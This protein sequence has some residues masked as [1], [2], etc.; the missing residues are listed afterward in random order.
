MEASSSKDISCS[1]VSMFCTV[2]EQQSELGNFLSFPSDQD[3]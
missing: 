3:L 2:P 1:N